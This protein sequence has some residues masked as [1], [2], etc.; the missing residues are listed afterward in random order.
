M[1]F[2]FLFV[3]SIIAA[4]TISCKK[5]TNNIISTNSLI[6]VGNTDSFVYAIDATTGKQKWKFKTDDEVVASPAYAD[7]RVFIGNKS[8]HFYAIDVNT[9]DTAWTHNI[10]IWYSCPLVVNNVVYSVSINDSSL[11]AFKINSTKPNKQADILWKF[12][13]DGRIG[14]SIAYAN[15]K[16]Y[17]ACND[18]KIYALE[19]KSTMAE[20]K[21]DFSVEMYSNTDLAVVGN[22]IYI[23]NVDGVLHAIEDK[24]TNAE[25]KWTFNMGAE[26]RTSPTIT[27]GL[28]YISDDSLCAL[29]TDIGVLSRDQRLKW[30]RHIGST[31]RSSATI[32]NGIIYVGGGDNKIYAINSTDGIDVWPAFNVGCNIESSPVIANGIL[33]IG[34]S[35]GLYA[36]NASTGQPI[37][38]SP[39]TASGA[40]TSS[41]CVLTSDGKVIYSSISGARQ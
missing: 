20:K 32:E 28:L 14:R 26:I 34:T 3:I 41:P 11:Y 21:W 1:K 5:T 10:G 13:L 35:C 37:W 9:G 36:L 2:K 22:I 23:G 17:L 31:P 38:S 12:K 25:G 4:F 40:F 33:Y 18:N 19:D 7:N 39:F 29:K 30:E 24:G 8:K 6:F 27:D 15:N 16:L